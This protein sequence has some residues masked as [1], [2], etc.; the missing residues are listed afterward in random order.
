VFGKR[1]VQR[2]LSGERWDG[3]VTAENDLVVAL[4][5]MEGARDAPSSSRRLS[6]PRLQKLLWNN[7]GIIRSSE[8]LRKADLQLEFWNREYTREMDRS[9]LELESA[10]CTARLITKMALLREESRGVHYR[11]DFPQ[12]SP[13]WRRHII[14][15]SSSLCASEQ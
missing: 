13:R 11:S 10:L 7:V 9:S 15:R 12:E 14:F 2:A 8:G 3:K 6:F 5:E 4:E 1:I